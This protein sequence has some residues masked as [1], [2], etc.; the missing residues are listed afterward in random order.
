[1]IDS[2][3]KKLVEQTDLTFDEASCAMEEIMSGK[4]SQVLITAFLIGLRTKGE[5][6]EE[7]AGAATAMRNAAVHIPSQR[8]HMIDTCG[9]GGDGSGTF[10]I[11]TVT[12]FIISGAGYTVAKHGNKSVSSRCGSADVLT[13]LGVNINIAP[14]EISTCLDTIGI[15]FLFA[16]LL[17][18]AMKNAMPVR[19]E[20]GLRTIFNLLGPLTNPARVTAQLMGVY[21]EKLVSIIG[22]VLPRLGVKHA[23]V[24]HGQGIDEITNLGKTHAC[25][26]QENNVEIVTI[27]PKDFGL[28]VA[29]KKDISGGDALINA[30]HIT[31]IL[32][33]KRD[34]RRDVALMNAAAGILIA[35]RDAG[36]KRAHDLKQAFGIAEES[37][38]S[39]AA[40][41]KLEELAAFTNK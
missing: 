31:D 8:A 7:I 34:K 1:M 4:V 25:I 6:I 17:H 26:V 41:K 40:L 33:G 11:S 36:D 30:V 24:V 23:M 14:Q 32:K 19:K 29:A 37:I 35:S 5:T 39:G 38:D 28:S 22:N 13:Q 9:T 2:A 20:L 15:G 18:G 27:E 3:I 10:N 16:P 12:A 21:D